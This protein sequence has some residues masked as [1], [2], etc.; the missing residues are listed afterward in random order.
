MLYSVRWPGEFS[1]AM[2]FGF[3]SLIPG[4]LMIGAFYPY[5]L[6]RALLQEDQTVGPTSVRAW[7]F[8]NDLPAFVSKCRLPQDRGGALLQ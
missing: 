1:F 4:I 3:T 8:E 7:D 5:F 2:D 6:V